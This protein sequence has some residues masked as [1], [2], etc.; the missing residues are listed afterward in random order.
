M[1]RGN[2]RG[3][4]CG[5]RARG[6]GRGKGS[7]RG[8]TGPMDELLNLNQAVVPAASDP[9]GWPR[10]RFGLG[11]AAC[12]TDVARSS[13]GSAIPG[14]VGLVDTVLRTSAGPIYTLKVQAN[15]QSP[16][17]ADFGLSAWDSGF[18]SAQVTFVKVAECKLQ[19]IHNAV[20][21]TLR[22]PKRVHLGE[23]LRLGTKRKNTADESA[24]LAKQVS[25]Y[26]HCVSA[27]LCLTLISNSLCL[28]R[29]LLMRCCVSEEYW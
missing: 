16:L 27:S 14:D 1:S 21:L 11:D 3:L 22:L 7:E 13:L 6:R 17:A 23:A 18:K 9:A 15:V 4:A 24:Q 25:S 26:T 2:G 29:V 12:F 5:G 28:H 20:G 19:P 8:V 10:V